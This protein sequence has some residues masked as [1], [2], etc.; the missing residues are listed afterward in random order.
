MKKILFIGCG[1]FFFAVSAWGQSAG[2]PCKSPVL[3]DLMN[4]VSGELEKNEAQ[5]K[6]TYEEI[7]R[8]ADQK[9]RK[10]IKRQVSAAQKSWLKARKEYCNIFSVMYG[11]GREGPLHIAM[12]L[13]SS[14]AHQADKLKIILEALSL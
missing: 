7:I 3:L 1:L 11:E 5:M 4:C 13:D 6:Q 2:D 9:K 10:E 8:L 14:A 12:C